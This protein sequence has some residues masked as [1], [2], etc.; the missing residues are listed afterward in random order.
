[1]LHPPTFHPRRRA[2][3]LAAVLGLGPLTLAA[4]PGARIWRCGNQYSDQPCASGTEL[5]PASAPTDSARAE[6]DATTRRTRAQ[7]EAMARERERAEAAAAGRSP[8]VIAHRSPW[9][10]QADA[11]EDKRARLQRPKRPR[12]EKGRSPKADGFTARGAASS[13]RAGTR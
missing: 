7:A 8:G 6:A 13:Q 3:L 9:P 2:L 1:M 11:E 12:T 4:Q 10:S 5:A